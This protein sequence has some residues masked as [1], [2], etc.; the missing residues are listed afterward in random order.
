VSHDCFLQYLPRLRDVHPLPDRWDCADP[1]R[2]QSPRFAR[3]RE[4]Q[5][6]QVAARC[7]RRQWTCRPRSRSPQSG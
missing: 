4:G 5:P 6:P 3:D 1:L 7:M 2:F